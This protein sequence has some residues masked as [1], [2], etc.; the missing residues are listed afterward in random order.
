MDHVSITIRHPRYAFGRLLAFANTHKHLHINCRR[1]NEARF[2][3]VESYREIAR[4][5]PPIFILASRCSVLRRFKV[6][7]LVPYQFTFPAM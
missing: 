5:Y 4:F 7:T 1:N 3:G 6:V 2:A